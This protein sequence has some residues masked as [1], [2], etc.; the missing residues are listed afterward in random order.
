MSPTPWT[1]S[2]P[3][4]GARSVV[5]PVARMTR[6]NEIVAD[7]VGPET[8]A[9]P[10][11]GSSAVTYPSTNV[12]SV[13]S[14][15]GRLG[16]GDRSSD[17]DVVHADAVDEIRPRVDHGDVDAPPGPACQPDGGHCSGEPAADDEDPHTAVGDVLF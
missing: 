5:L 14:R 15:L 2:P 6:S 16:S 1:C 13:P 3:G 4:I 12:T 8:M 9:R 11:S 7:A 17:G 10:A